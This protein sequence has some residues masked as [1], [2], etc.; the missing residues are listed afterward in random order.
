MDAPRRRDSQCTGSAYSKIR[1]QRTNLPLDVARDSEL[2]QNGGLFDYPGYP[3]NAYESIL[4][5]PTGPLPFRENDADYKAAN[6]FAS[7]A[8]IFPFESVLVHGESQNATPDYFTASYHGLSADQHDNLTWMDHELL[9]SLPSDQP[10]QIGQ[11]Y[12][13]YSLL[14]STSSLYGTIENRESTSTP[15]LP[16]NSVQGNRGLPRRKSRYMIQ[17]I[18]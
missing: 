8:A 18:N 2:P 13:G 14:P 16:R 11:L 9:Q 5:N 4:L 17:E 1:D 15:P 12:P 7:N 10:N 6:D 3:D